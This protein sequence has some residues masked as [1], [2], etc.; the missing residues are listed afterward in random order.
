M[1]LYLADSQKILVQASQFVAFTFITA[2]L[3]VLFFMSN[4]DTDYHYY[5]MT[6]RLLIITQMLPDSNIAYL[7]T[8]PN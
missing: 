6:I 3:K 7:R 5:Y 1:C 4:H 2:V 8:K